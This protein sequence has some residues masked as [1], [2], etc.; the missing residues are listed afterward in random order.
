[1][2]PLTVV[3]WLVEAVKLQLEVSLPETD[4]VKLGEAVK[5]FVSLPVAVCTG[6]VDS[7]ALRDGVG[8]PDAA[9][10]QDEV[11]LRLL[12]GVEDPL[13]ARVDVIEA[14]ASG[15]PLV[16]LLAASVL[17]IELLAVG[18]LVAETLS[19][20]VPVTDALAAGEPEADATG[21]PVFDGLPLAS[22][23]PEKEATILPELEGLDD[24]AGEGLT[25]GEEPGEAGVLGLGEADG[26]AVGD[27]DGSTRKR[28]RTMV[29]SS[30]PM[31]LFDS[32]AMP[33]VPNGT[34]APPSPHA[35]MA[36]VRRASRSSGARLIAVRPSMQA[37]A[38][39]SGR[40]HAPKRLGLLG[41]KGVGVARCR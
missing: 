27:E 2:L 26:D 13:S 22:G 37:A 14:L 11:S 17:D 41:R 24:A 15:V 34:S 31:P 10:L 8:L 28:P 25:L 3:V 20:G 39:F 1:M 18:T 21:L 33:G 9:T 12:L 4:R 30:S 35:A 16:E 40:R 32:G 23:E 5:L 29:A 7:E 36:S 19:A 6:V 38:L